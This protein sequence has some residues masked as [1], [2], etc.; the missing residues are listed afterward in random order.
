M[1]ISEIPNLGMPLRVEVNQ[2]FSSSPSRSFG[3]VDAG[4][5]D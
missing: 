1:D 4:R 3:V 5:L 2:V